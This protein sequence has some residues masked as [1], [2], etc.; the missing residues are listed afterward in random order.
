MIGIS[1]N[2]PKIDLRKLIV[3][4]RYAE[5]GVIEVKCKR[6]LYTKGGYYWSVFI[7]DE[8]RDGIIKLYMLFFVFFVYSI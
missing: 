8:M 6:I 7:G 4:S 3:K 1:R 2:E 5:N